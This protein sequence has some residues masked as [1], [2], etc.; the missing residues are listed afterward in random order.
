MQSQPLDATFAGQAAARLRPSDRRNPLPA[1]AGPSASPM[2]RVNALGHRRAGET[3]AEGFLFVRCSRP[4][5]TAFR[6]PDLDL[7]RP[8]IRDSGIGL[9][10]PSFWR[11]GLWQDRLRQRPYSHDQAGQVDW[12]GFSGAMATDIWWSG[13]YFPRGGGY[14]ITPL[15]QT[16]EMV[17]C[18]RE[19]GKLSR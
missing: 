13:G 10:P 2:R 12:E 3:T 7:S 16:L 4:I 6:N 15:E 18:T 11:R 9:T 1:G 5:A 19:I 8:D 17:A 14:R